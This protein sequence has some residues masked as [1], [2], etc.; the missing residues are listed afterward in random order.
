MRWSL[1]TA[2]GPIVEVL[3]ERLLGR[4]EEAA[5][6]LTRQ[7]P[8]LKIQTWSAPVGSLTAYQGHDLG[9]D[10]L[11]PAARESEPGSVAL[12]IGVRHLTSEPMLCTADVCWAQGGPSG[13]LDL[14]P[15]PVAWSLEALRSV[16][17]RL[18]ELIE[19]LERELD[20]LDRTGR[21]G[22]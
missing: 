22:A 1:G 21:R 16:E 18:P 8:R 12:T 6:R 9:I 10:C 4:L 14:L 13:G 19:S 17:A 15:E 7:Y 5:T 3:E 11:D 2:T 20:V